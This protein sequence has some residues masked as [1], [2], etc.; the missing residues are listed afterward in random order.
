MFYILKS[1]YLYRSRGFFFLINI[2]LFC[3]MSPVKGGSTK[4]GR[5]VGGKSELKSS[6][7]SNHTRGGVRDPVVFMYERFVG[8]SCGVASPRLFL[9]LEVVGILEAAPLG[10]GG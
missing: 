2:F 6:V 8:G 4:S 1:A 3:S 9:P 10:G 5:C 7:S